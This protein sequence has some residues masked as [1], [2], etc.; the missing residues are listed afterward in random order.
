MNY[1]AVLQLYRELQPGDRVELKH[2]VKVGFRNWEKVTVGEVVRTERRRHGLH[3][4]RNFD[5]KVF[6]D[7]IVLRRDDGELTTVTLDEFSEL[8]KV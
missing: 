4:G 6:S 1:S 7:I 5:D 3:Y 2:E 8:R